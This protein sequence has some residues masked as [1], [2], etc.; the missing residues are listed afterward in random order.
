MSCVTWAAE[1]NKVNNLI[2][3]E[4]SKKLVFESAIRPD[5]AD[6]VKGPVKVLYLKSVT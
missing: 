2:N 4:L 5:D 3:A 6:R 1:E